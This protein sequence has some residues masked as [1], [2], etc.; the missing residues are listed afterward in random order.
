MKLNRRM[1]SPACVLAVFLVITLVSSATSLSSSSTAEE[2]ASTVT[3]YRDA[4]GTPHVFGK[5][6]AS[7]VFGFAYAQAED[8]VP[9]MEED[10]ILSIGRGTE[11][12]GAEQ[13]KWDRLNRA[14]EVERFAR[15]DYDAISPHMRE[16]CD[17]FAAGANYYLTRH[18]KVHL[19]VLERI[20]PWYPLAFIRYIYYQNGFALDDKLGDSPMAAA[21]P[22]RDLGMRNGS[23]G[24]VIGPS[25]SAAGHAMLLINPHLGFFGPGQ[26]YEGHIHSDEGW[27]F[28][29]YARFGF[30]FPYI[31][32]NEQVG[33][34]STDNAADSVDGYIEKF[35]DPRNPLAYRYGSEH[36]I[37]TEHN[38]TFRIKTAQGFESQTFRLLR[39]HHGPLLTTYHGDPVAARL[40]KYE[41]HGW[42]E[43]W[44]RM[45]KAHSL[46]E[47]KAAISPLDMLFGNV[48][49]AGSDGN[50]FYVY[51]SAVPRRDPAFDWSKPV[52]GSDPRTEWQGYYALDELPQLTNPP[53]G[54]ME[55]CNTSPYLLTTSANPAP[56]RYPKFMVREGQAPG[57]E[58]DNPRGRA[59]QRILSQ[60]SHFTFDQWAAA[61]FDTHV[62]TAD[63][64]L[65][66]WLALTR[67]QI[68]SS[69]PQA[70]ALRDA[71]S[72]LEHWNHESAIDSVA[73]TIFTSWHSAMENKI[74]SP[75]NLEQ[76][77]ET[78]LTELTQKVGQ[79]RVTFGEVD[80][81]QRSTELAKPPFGFPP[82]DD[83]KP[84]L[85]VA[86]VNGN[87]GAIFTLGTAPGSQNKRKYGIHGATYVSV[88]EFGPHTQA[89]SIMTFGESGDPSNKHFFD[90]APLY[91]AGRFK[92][93]W[94]S[95][96]EVKQHAEAS[97]HAGEEP[98]TK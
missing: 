46:A 20:E 53:P 83:N 81:L 26:V 95:L 40:P 90:Q 16:L 96:E 56:T 65:P 87:D 76:A 72:E 28:T 43:E 80:R 51:N 29:G 74:A 5:T 9:Q 78:M 3:I 61:A 17:A 10:F 36:R 75:V 19:R 4:Y 38:E 47:L 21:N 1:I 42:M 62:I 63:E 25:R 77:L 79:W 91:A 41:S 58:G 48:M 85:P 7:T 55:N 18:S 15:A 27:E 93:S 68:D 22:I 11:L 44:Y 89:R 66:S 82:F 64:L 54:W 98:I 24:W 71:L 97:Y 57:W 6:D 13:M 12:Y 86:G 30:P 8:N 70:V 94:F 39:T 33:W 52:D 73:M 50:I 88:V 84:S 49:S 35:D 59:S 23:N 92:E 2:L 32:H 14:L 60:N 34:M 69:N 45:T 31:G 67:Q 37:A